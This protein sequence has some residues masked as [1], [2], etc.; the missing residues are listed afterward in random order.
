MENVFSLP[1]YFLNN[2]LLPSLP[3]CK[4]TVYNTHA[5]Y[6]LI[7]CVNGKTF[8]QQQ[9]ISS[10]VFAVSK[11]HTDFSYGFLTAGGR[12]VSAPNPSAVQG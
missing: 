11:N 7:N 9:A 10:Q 5:K 2:F 4:N 8:G 6:A 1:Y 12:G 3:Y